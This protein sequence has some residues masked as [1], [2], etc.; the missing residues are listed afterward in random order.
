MRSD[1]RAASSRTQS[2]VNGS[3]RSSSR[4]FQIRRSACLASSVIVRVL[5]S[6]QQLQIKRID[7]IGES[8]SSLVMVLH[9][10]ETLTNHRSRVSEYRTTSSSLSSVRMPDN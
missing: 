3:P 10:R 1:L 2:K 5:D 6:P 8:R 7:S 4:L 9:Y